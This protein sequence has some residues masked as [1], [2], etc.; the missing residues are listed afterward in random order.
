[1]GLIPGNAG[2]P[3]IASDGLQVDHISE[4]TAGHNI[5]FNNNIIAPGSLIQT[6][7]LNS[8]YRA[9]GA[10]SGN[11]F[12]E[13]SSNYRVSI[14]PKLATSLIIVNY[15]MIIGVSS[16]YSSRTLMKFTG[17]RF[18]GGTAYSVSSIGAVNGNRPAIAGHIFRWSNG[19]DL[20]DNY[21]LNCTILDYP[22]TTST[23][24]YGFKFASEDSITA[25]FGYSSY[26]NVSGADSNVLIIVQEI[27]Q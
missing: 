25:L 11:T 23:I 3:T 14:T 13:V 24:Q 15:Q 1:M 10:F 22:N 5:V 9:S 19:W 20:N 6:Q 2:Q 18:V 27:A 7:V 16:G 12:L 26:N 21:P 4:L 17:I 8:A